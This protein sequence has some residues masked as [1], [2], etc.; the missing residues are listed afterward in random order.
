[1]LRSYVK[2]CLFHDSSNWLEGFDVK[3]NFSGDQYAILFD[4][5]VVI[6]NMN[7]EPLVTIEHNMRLH[8]VRYFQHPTHG[9]TLVAG[10]D[11]KLIK[12]YS[13]KDGKELQV[14]KGHGARYISIMF[15]N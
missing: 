15:L 2:V 6:Y 7:A 8:C 3:W 12:F 13:A 11:D 5:K 14:L 1:M 4:R 10:T 9:E